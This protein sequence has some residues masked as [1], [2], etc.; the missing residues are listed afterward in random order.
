MTSPLLPY[1]LAALALLLLAAPAAQAQHEGLLQVDDA[2]E[3]V[4]G[5]QRALGRL[6]GAFLGARPLSAYAAQ[7]Y[8]DSALASGD[9]FGAADYA[10]LRRLT[11][12]AAGPGVGVVNRALPFLY[13][14][15]H[16]FYSARAEDYA[17]EVSPLAVLSYG[18][19]RQTALADREATV[20]V[21]QNT[22]GVRAAGHIGPHVFFE[23]RLEENQ[24]RPVQP[25]YNPI[26]RSVPRIGSS[27]L[28]DGEVY[29]Y[30][31]ATGVV[32]FR[33]EYFEARFGRDR[34][35]WGF[36]GT[37]LVLSDY[38]TVYDQL[39]LRTQ[40]WRIHYTNL[41]TQLT[42]FRPADETGD[43][44]VPRKFAAF[45]R[46]AIDLPARVQIEL[47]ESVVFAT[48]TTGNGRRDGFDF[49]YLNPIIFYRAVEHDLGSPDNAL[50]GGGI[51]WVAT[52]GV[53]LY[54]QGILDELSVERFSGDWWGNKWGYIL[55]AYLVDPGWGDVRLRGFD[56]RVEYARQR[57]FLYGHRTEATAYVHYGD[58]LGHPAGPNTSDLAVFVNYRP[59][60]RLVTALNLAFTQRGRAPE[61]EV[62]GADPTR[63]NRLRD[64][65]RDYDVPTLQGVRQRLLLAE[66]RVGYELLPS[67]F[68][69]AV[70]RAESVDDAERG[71][72]RYVAPFA[73]LRWGLPFPSVRY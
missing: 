56:L 42:A 51:S 7:A 9:T 63:S 28:Q 61:G 3:H 15:G 8:A 43:G 23:A 36:G 71:L 57:P 62:V 14:D 11:G 19:A 34:N 13:A 53:E 68:L 37:S 66:A 54:A 25:A 72:D 6:P 12:R 67:L 30:F 55:G 65:S 44:L 59:W 50:L 1:R 24:R 39:Q 26:V 16:S 38:A 20:P 69:E 27:K 22:R 5:R 46:L 64:T 73:S 40:V 60:P 48:D 32:G 18:R 35:Q 21:W 31:V 33:S 17:F 41:F 49:A 70:V 47:F 45:H 29:D 10:L 2:F 58:V 4:L 52:P